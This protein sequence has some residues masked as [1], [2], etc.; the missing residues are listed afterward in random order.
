MHLINGPFCSYRYEDIESAHTIY[1]VAKIQRHCQRV[2]DRTDGRTDGRIYYSYY[3]TLHARQQR[4]W[5][6]L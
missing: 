1:V 4:T 5:R 3:S 6:V 2:T